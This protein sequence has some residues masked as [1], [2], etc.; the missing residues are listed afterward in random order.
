MSEF[1]KAATKCDVSM[2]RE[3]PMY[4]DQTGVMEELYHHERLVEQTLKTRRLLD[5]LDEEEAREKS[6]A[7]TSIPTV[8][9]TNRDMEV[10]VGNGH[11]VESKSYREPPMTASALEK[12]PQDRNA[13]SRAIHRSV[14]SR[15]NIWQQSLDS[16]AVQIRSLERS[17][18]KKAAEE[19]AA[20]RRDVERELN[21][22][23]ATRQ[24]T[25]HEAQREARRLALEQ[26]Q[27]GNRVHPIDVLQKR[28]GADLLDE[29]EEGSRFV[30]AQ[31]EHE[32]KGVDEVRDI[33][34]M[35]DVK[36]KYHNPCKHVP[37]PW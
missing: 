24:L 34:S 5:A 13:G 27:Q 2:A 9:I 7:E 29:M 22:L 26:A 10:L 4:I 36:Y 3:A 19:E 28:I 23:I 33:E 30:A 1:F 37:R 20:R 16:K 8:P 35:K 12:A 11:T 15:M 21:A 6:A 31:L 18:Q 25:A 14:E 17:E 32:E